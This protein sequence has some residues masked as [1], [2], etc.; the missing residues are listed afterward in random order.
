MDRKTASEETTGTVFPSITL[1]AECATRKDQ[2][3]KVAV[4]VQLVRG[5]EFTRLEFLSKHFQSGLFVVSVVSED[6][7]LPLMISKSQKPQ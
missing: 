6:A 7:C 5:I 1:P 2:K 4:Q 3:K